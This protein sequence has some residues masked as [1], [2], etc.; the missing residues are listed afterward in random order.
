METK[1]AKAPWDLRVGAT[2]I[3]LYSNDKAVV[4][5]YKPRNNNEMNFANAFLVREAPVMFQLLARV[6]KLVPRSPEEKVLLSEIEK[7]LAR[8]VNFNG[9]NNS[10]EILTLQQQATLDFK[11]DN[12]FAKFYE[13]LDARS[14]F[15]ENACNSLSALISQSPE[16]MKLSPQKDN[17]TF[18]A[19]L[20]FLQNAYNLGEKKYIAINEK[21]DEL[22]NL[23]N[24]VVNEDI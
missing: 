22:N 13:K 18:S 17:E 5:V 21:L 15:W 6:L 20:G 1:F 7:V 12:T 10:Q 16:A 8:I 9:K 2:V 24:S 23:L 11:D 19:F 14:K 4:Y 3:S